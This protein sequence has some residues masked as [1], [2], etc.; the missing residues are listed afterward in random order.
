MTRRAYSDSESLD[1]KVKQRKPRAAVSA[2]PIDA[3]VKMLRKTG[4]DVTADGLRSIIRN[5]AV[6]T[7]ACCAKCGTELAADAPVWRE[8]IELVEFLRP[9]A[10]VP[11]CGRCVS[12]VAR[13]LANPAQPCAGCG[14]PVHQYM[15]HQR[16]RVVCCEACARSARLAARRQQRTEARGTRQ[17]ENESCGE[18]FEPTRTDGRFCS[19]RCRQQAYRRRKGVT[20]DETRTACPDG[21]SRNVASVTDDIIPTSRC[22]PTSRNAKQ[23]ASR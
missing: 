17:C 8:R 11:V 6:A 16:A 12:P 5:A 19:S 7:C 10:V 22:F 23:K 9:W 20:D 1:R 14:R 18:T 13:T 2:D 21:V 15:A 4:I 3:D